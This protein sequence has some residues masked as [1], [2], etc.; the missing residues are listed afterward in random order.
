VPTKKPHQRSAPTRKTKS[1]SKPK[2]SQ[3]KR[4]TSPAW[5]RIYL[6]S[7][8]LDAIAADLGLPIPSQPSESFDVADAA[9]EIARLA[10]NYNRDTNPDGRNVEAEKSDWVSVAGLGADLGNMADEKPGA[11]ADAIRPIAHELCY[12]ACDFLF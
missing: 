6:V 5:E 10:A 9:R 4:Y 8:E 3:T 2:P 11:P 1:K 12:L 7:V